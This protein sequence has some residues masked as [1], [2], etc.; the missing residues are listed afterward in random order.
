MKT[1]RHDLRAESRARLTGPTRREFLR[2]SAGLVA[3]AVAAGRLGE[4]S[5]ATGESKLVIGYGIPLLTL[6]PHKHD[7][8][9]HES[10]LR[11]IYEPLV[12]LSADLT[13]IEPLLATS[14]ARLNDLTVQ[15]KLRQ[16]VKFHNGEEFDGQAVKFT[17][18][19]VFNPE[20]KAPLLTTYQTIERVDVLDKYTVNV[21]TK[22]PDPLL[23]RRMSSFHMNILPPKYFSTASAD[24]LARKPVGTGT[25]R[26]VSWTKDADFVMEA[27]PAYWGTVK[28]TIQRVT[29]RTIPETGTR[30]AALLA[31]DADIVTAVPPDEIERVNRSGKARVI[32]LP[33]NRI[34]F[35]FINVRKEPLS[36]KQVRQAL[37]YASNMDGII[38]AI[39]GGHGFR[40]AVIS[41]PWHVGYD[42]NIPPFPY[43][44]VKAKALLAQAGYAGGIAINMHAIQGRYPKDKEIAEALAG[45]LGKVGVNVN[46]KFWEWGAWLDAADAA[47]LD[48]LIFASWGNPWHD[49]DGT[50]YPLFKSNTRYTKNWTGY[51]NEALDALLEEGR[52]TLDEG[53]RREIYSRIQRLMQDDSPALFMHALEDIYGV[54]TRV[55]WKPRSDEMVRHNEM[56]LK[57]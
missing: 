54:N 15:F 27:N 51:A 13:K 29:M 1:L 11:N 53:K 37:N 36:N 2:R 18:E 22:K 20:T 23:V 43:D 56:T 12:T 25:Y 3:G 41:N 24:E 38:K 31:G 33:G 30:V 46:L 28:A 50:Y 35:Y 10:V 42:P 7:N 26:F 8:S 32:T 6:D 48:G 44:P 39:L 47:K 49:A 14:Y 9:V 40:R 17:V 5:A 34:P 4:L 57:G 16:G 21:V 19:R 52:T 55:E 45:E